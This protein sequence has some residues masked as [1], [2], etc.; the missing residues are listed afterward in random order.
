MDLDRTELIPPLRGYSPHMGSEISAFLADTLR[1][2]RGSSTGT[3]QWSPSVR[4]FADLLWRD[5]IVHMY[6]LAMLDE[7][8]EPNRTVSDIPELVRALDLLSTRAPE[9]HPDPGRSN[10]FPV[11]TLFVHM[12]ETP[13]GRVLCRNTAFNDGLRRIL[14][15]W[16]A[17]LDSP[18]SRDVLHTGDNGWLC[19]SSYERN[20]LH[21]YIIPD[22]ADPHW[23]F[24]SFN[25]FFHRQIRPDRRPVAAPHDSR[26]I[27][28]PNDG[29]LYKVAQ[30]VRGFDRFWIKCQPYSIYHMLNGDRI[31]RKFEG[32][33]VFQS[34]LDGRN[35]HR[36]WSPVAGT[37]TRIETIPG[38]MFS[39][40]D[41]L[42][43]DT[44]AGTY[45]QAYMSCVNTRTV[46]T[47]DAEHPGI[48]TLCL[49]AIGISEISSI[50]MSVEVG[51]R[52]RKG[53]ELG[54]FS[55]GGS[56]VCLVFRPG[57]VCGFT[58]DTD[59]TGT[60]LG[61]RGIALR[62]GQEIAVH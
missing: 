55:Y 14:A 26:V 23:G 49:V 48:G 61:T 22:P 8:P 29:T 4:A 38:L 50:S 36:F 56:S 52:V 21:D 57:A 11:S 41:A 5:P 34:F 24:A 31:S 58:I 32:G 25:D 3:A 1:E 54:Y 44:T 16:C 18:K 40:V 13:A 45:S 37:V 12:M 15:S 19:A 28:S 47:I 53:A 62:A 39:S 7:V 17:H 35:Y 6:T 2:L 51:S 33:T 60:E 46:V 20:N 9:Y 30:D 59:F 43:G 10:F 42:R 27:V